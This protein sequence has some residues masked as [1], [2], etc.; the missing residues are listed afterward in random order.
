[1]SREV[2]LQMSYSKELSLSVHFKFDQAIDLMLKHNVPITE[3]LTE[4]LTPVKRM[5]HPLLAL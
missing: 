2:L 4:K 3:E 1:M 5:H